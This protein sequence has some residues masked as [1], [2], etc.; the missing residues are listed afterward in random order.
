MEE[1]VSGIKRTAEDIRF[2]KMIRQRDNWTCMRCGKQKT[3]ESGPTLHCAHNFTRRTQVTRFDPSNALA[4]C[5]G[6]HQFIDSHSEEKER[7][8]RLRF[9]NDE[10]DRV[11]ALAH[12]RRDRV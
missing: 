6:C 1:T 3:P 5:Y 7:L 12:G 2:S 11:A 9:G 4:L 10:Y 8:F